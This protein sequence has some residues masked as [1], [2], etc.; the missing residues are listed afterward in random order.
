M[1]ATKEQAKKK[2]KKI[3][4]AIGLVY[5]KVVVGEQQSSVEID[6]EKFKLV[7]RP[8]L[9]VKLKERLETNADAYL[10]LRVYP[11]FNLFNQ[12]FS[13]Q[14]VNFYPEKPKQPPVNQF[15]LAGVW[16]YIPLLPDMP[17]MTIYRNKL[18]G[19]EDKAT[20][21]QH[22]LPV[23]GFDEKPYRHGSD[24]PEDPKKRTFYEIV[25]RFD[26]KQQE[27]QF[28]ILLD[29]TEKLPYRVLRKKKK[30]KKKK[31]SGVSQLEL[32]SMDFAALQKTASKLRESGFLEGKIAG[33]GV[34]KEFL[35]NKIQDTVS[36]HPEAIKVLN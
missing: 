35:T 23:K 22:H 31:Q 29:S 6:G 14:L 3:F 25:V 28:L 32:T 17:V 26:A 13:F 10:Y 33:K 36:T 21:R 9:L 5:G 4:Q 12:E 20:F 15:I 19:K 27:F 1:T 24:N 18:R 16:Q 2:S 34:T 8:N 30:K 11:Q 7:C